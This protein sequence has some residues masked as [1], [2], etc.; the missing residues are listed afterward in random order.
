MSVRERQIYGNIIKMAFFLKLSYSKVRA[1][2]TYIPRRGRPSL[3][4]AYSACNVSYTLRYK[5]FYFR[6]AH[7]LHVER[8]CVRI[9]CII[10]LPNGLQRFE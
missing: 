4:D 8:F 7:L 3:V 10:R 2:F 9:R 5:F 1:F 6:L